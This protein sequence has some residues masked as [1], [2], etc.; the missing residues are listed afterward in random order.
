MISLLTINANAVQFLDTNSD[1][2]NLTDNTK[3]YENLV[4]AGNNIDIKVPLYKDAT[5][6]GNNITIEGPIER[7]ALLA[8]QNITIRNTTIGAGAKIAGA[9]VTL[10]GVTIEEDV[11]IAAGQVTLKKVIVK[12]DALLSTANL[13]MTESNISKRLFYSG[14]SNE[15]LKPQVQGELI[16]DEKTVKEETEKNVNFLPNYFKTAGLISGL[17]LLSIMMYILFKAKKIYD[18]EIGID[19]SSGKHFTIGTVTSF[20]IYPILF[21]LTLISAGFLL[22]LTASVGS[23]FTVFLILVSPI[24]AYYLSVLI[25]KD[26]TKWYYPHIILV[27]LFLASLV[28]ILNV[29]V[30]ILEFALLMSVLGYYLKK[31]YEAKKTYLQ[32]V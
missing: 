5:I 11:F 6:A 19:K 26:K 20:A 18:P 31:G 24:N 16:V 27:L 28:P 23:L 9:N 3:R 22:P 1:T 10:E 4:T 29:I 12:G 32:T 21:I 7:N 8:G 25:F 17:T 2:V 15:N 30:G 14:P 13:N